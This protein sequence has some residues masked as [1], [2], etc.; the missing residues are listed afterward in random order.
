MVKDKTFKKYV[1]VMA[2]VKGILAKAQADLAAAQKPLTKSN[3]KR[4]AV[5]EVGKVVERLG[6]ITKSIVQTKRPLQQLGIMLARYDNPRRGAKTPTAAPGAK[7][8]RKAPA[9][10]STAT[11][12]PA[13][14]EQAAAP[15]A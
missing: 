13:P 11:Q 10:K 1:G 4:E 7:R 5:N 3:M 2:S 8:P 6:S 15:T 9:K 12:A 14:T